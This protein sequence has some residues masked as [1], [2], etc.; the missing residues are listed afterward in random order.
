MWSVTRPT[1]AGITLWEQVLEQVL[2]GGWDQSQ[3]AYYAAKLEKEGVLVSSAV[4]AANLPRTQ[5]REYS[6]EVKF[7][8]EARG[9]YV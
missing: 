9:W 1:A 8:K 4:Q 2:T 5:N 7:S 6:V 3:Y